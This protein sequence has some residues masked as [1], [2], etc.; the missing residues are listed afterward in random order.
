[1]Y[2]PH[3]KDETSELTCLQYTGRDGIDFEPNID[4]HV[5]NFINLIR[6]KYISTATESNIM[7][8]AQKA[9]FFTIDVITDLATGAP[10]GDLTSDSDQNEYLRTASE[11]QPVF[12]MIS[13]LPALTKII[14]IPSL[15]KWLFPT[16]QDEIGMGKLI[17][18][19]H[20][21]VV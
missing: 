1:V 5:Q 12:V 19:V 21:C 2:A 16:S 13:S 3:E 14:Q 7:D 8:L 15:G 17:G 9:Q 10:F 6:T 11:A 4:I 20:L 18:S